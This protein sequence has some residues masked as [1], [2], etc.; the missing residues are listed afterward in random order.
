MDHTEMATV[1]QDVA[2]RF[3]PDDL[4]EARF[5]QSWHSALASLETATFARMLQQARHVVQVLPALDGASDEMPTDEA[6]TRAD[7]FLSGQFRRA[8]AA[9]YTG[10]KP[11]SLRA[12]RTKL[13][14]QQVQP[15][16]L[17]DEEV[18]HL[19]ADRVSPA[20]VLRMVLFPNGKFW[21]CGEADARASDQSPP[22]FSGEPVALP[23]HD[24]DS[25]GTYDPA[26]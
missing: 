1:E 25:S 16:D 21:L 19:A 7:Q 15:V 5:F 20:S 11:M 17:S 26:S 14:R 24:G 9:G 8:Q 2:P 4:T 13:F 6:V 12:K 18:K 3:T 22:A 23:P 10:K